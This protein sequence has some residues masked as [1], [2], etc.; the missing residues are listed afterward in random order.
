MWQSD[1]QIAAECRFAK[2]GK[3]MTGMVGLGRV[4]DTWRVFLLVGGKYCLPMFLIW[5]G[6]VPERMFGGNAGCCTAPQGSGGAV[7]WLSV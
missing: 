2:G 6:V 3:T 5:L 7:S 1:R 4:L